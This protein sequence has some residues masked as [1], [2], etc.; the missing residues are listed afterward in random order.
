MG[1]AGAGDL[2]DHVLGEFDREEQSVLP[3]VLTHIAER[4]QDWATTD[5]VLQ[6]VIERA[7]TK[8]RPQQ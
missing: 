5:D 6:K 7:N 1:A 4:C 8:A 2:I 3:H